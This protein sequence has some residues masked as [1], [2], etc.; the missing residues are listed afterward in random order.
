MWI[1][2][3]YN[4]DELVLCIMSHDTDHVCTIHLPSHST[5][6]IKKLAKM[7]HVCTEEQ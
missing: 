6:S 3:S 1:R 7:L 5:G 2:N 4:E